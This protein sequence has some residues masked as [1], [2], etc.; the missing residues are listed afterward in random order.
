MYPETLFLSSCVI[1]INKEMYAI[2]NSIINL[3]NLVPKEVPSKTIYNAYT[4]DE[5]KDTINRYIP[6][7]IN[8][9]RLYIEEEFG[10][11]HKALFKYVN[12]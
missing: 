7:I 12:A 8:T 2:I 11:I 10:F 5:I 3:N 1:P 4:F 6:D 9:I